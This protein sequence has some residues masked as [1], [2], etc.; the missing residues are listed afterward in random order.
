M[1]RDFRSQDKWLPGVIQSKSGS[2]WYDV[3]LENGKIAKRRID[4][5]QDRSVSTKQLNNTQ[6]GDSTQGLSP[7]TPESNPSPNA[8]VRQYQQREHHPP[9]QDAT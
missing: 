9:S 1:A 5:L 2:V 4:H 8:P 7:P 3:E 6:P